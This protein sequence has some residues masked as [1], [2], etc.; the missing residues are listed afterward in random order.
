MTSSYVLFYILFAVVFIIFFLFSL[1]QSFI[2]FIFASPLKRLEKK[3]DKICSSHYYDG[4]RTL[5]EA[6]DMVLDYVMNHDGDYEKFRFLFERTM[7]PLEHDNKGELIQQISWSNDL[8]RR[9]E[10]VDNMFK[11]R[12]KFPIKR[13]NFVFFIHRT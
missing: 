2:S 3:V 1:L 12:A 4:S 9:L 6:Q 13:K 11:K 10:V 5:K 8:Y 7:M